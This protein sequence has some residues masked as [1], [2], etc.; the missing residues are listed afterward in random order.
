M[1][2]KLPKFTPSQLETIK[3]ERSKSMG[4]RTSEQ[5]ETSTVLQFETIET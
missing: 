1:Q 3:T 4:S 5:P 2:G